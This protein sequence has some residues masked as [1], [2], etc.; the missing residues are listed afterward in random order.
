MN[1][2]S[3]NSPSSLPLFSIGVTTYDRVEMLI[4]TL[5]SVLAQTFTDFEVIVS[6]DNP[7]RIL[8]GESLGVVDPR[9]R[10]VN[11]PKNLGEF[12]NMQFLLKSSRGRYFTWL[13]D[14]DLYHPEFFSSAH[15]ILTKY[16]F[17][18]CFF[19]SFDV[20]DIIDKVG[21][22]KTQG[23]VNADEILMNGADFL[24]QYLA[25]KI[26]TIGVM[27]FFDR[28]YL[29]S[30]GG[31][32][33]GSGDGKGMFCEYM[34]LLTTGSLDRIA[35]I[36][37][38]L[39]FFRDNTDRWCITNIDSEM[40]RR[41]GQN[42]IRKGITVLTGPTFRASFFFSF[43]AI[44]LKSIPSYI[45]ALKRSGHLTVKVWL[46]YLYEVWKDLSPLRKSNLYFP[47][48]AALIIVWIKTILSE[49]WHAVKPIRF[50]VKKLVSK[51]QAFRL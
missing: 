39:I 12:Y 46:P 36:N 11:Q 21:V 47:A 38:P 6:N 1:V 35:Y 24:R 41:A 49:V 4:E 9:I 25:R 3:K 14:D 40:Y 18:P 2:A 19:T 26:K 13:A 43:Y 23:S 15:R 16:D 31:L 8:T 5:N 37:A 34:L 44:L 17:P 48:V 45:D 7:D 32:E 27:G 10:F 42:L 22:K 30:I 51:N 20:F 50:F 33:D 28:D 29:M